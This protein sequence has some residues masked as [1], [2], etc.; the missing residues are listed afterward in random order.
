MTNSTQVTIA[1][2][3]QMPAEFDRKKIKSWKSKVFNILGDIESY[4]L[5][6]D[7]DGGSWEYTDEIIRQT[8]PKQHRGDC[9]LVIVN[10][11]LK[12]NYYARGLGDNT[13][14]ITF[15][16]IKHLLLRENI[17]LENVIYRLIYAYTIIFKRWGNIPSIGEETTRYTHDETRGCL[18]DMAGYKYD[19]IYSCH[20]PRIC[21]ECVE[22][23]KNDRISEEAI[24]KIQNEVSRIKKPMFYRIAGFVKKHPLWSIVITSISAIVLGA[25]GSYLATI[26]YDFTK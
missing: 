21:F 15:H 20:K 2:I 5:N 24:S 13:A 10:V 7:S 25:I 14:V 12:G 22:R 11:P 4:S 18:F 19:I 1:T 8:L 3:G 9:L 6:G 26:F 23:M 17:P 16:E